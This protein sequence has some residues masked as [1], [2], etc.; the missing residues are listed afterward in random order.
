MRASVM[1]VLIDSLADVEASLANVSG[2]AAVEKAQQL[3]RHKEVIET[4][5]MNA[6]LS[7]TNPDTREMETLKLSSWELKSDNQKG[8]HIEA[9]TV[10]DRHS[11]RLANLFMRCP[12]LGVVKFSTD[13]GDGLVLSCE[14]KAAF[15][16]RFS[17]DGSCST[18]LDELYSGPW[19]SIHLTSDSVSCS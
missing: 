10:F 16:E 11:I 7:F 1:E 9:Y 4:N 5:R 18:I 3:A 8:P 6:E 13:L 15:V 17:I 12:D 14:M 2:E 19:V